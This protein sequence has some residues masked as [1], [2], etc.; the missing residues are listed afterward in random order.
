E[1]FVLG[2]YFAWLLKRTGSLWV[3]IACHALYNGV[4]FAAMRLLPAAV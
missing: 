3:P 1:V 2:I 4:L